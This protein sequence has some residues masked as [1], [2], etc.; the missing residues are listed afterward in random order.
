MRTVTL[1]L[2]FILTLLF[3]TSFAQNILIYPE[4]HR[5]SACIEQRQ[6]LVDKSMS[7]NNDFSI[8]E[9]GY[10]DDNYGMYLLSRDRNKIKDI[11]SF[12]YFDGLERNPSLENQI[13]QDILAGFQNSKL[14]GLESSIVEMLSTSLS[15]ASD[16][17]VLL[18][19]VN[20][21][22][23]SEVGSDPNLNDF[24]K[25]YFSGFL[26]LYKNLQTLKLSPNF[27]TLYQDYD[28]DQL[29]TNVSQINQSLLDTGKMGSFE[30]S[31]QR[32]IQLKPFFERVFFVL[33]EYINFGE[34]DSHLILSNKIKTLLG[35][36]NQS[37]IEAWSNAMKANTAIQVT[38]A[39]TQNDNF[40]NN[41]ENS[42]KVDLR[43]FAFAQNIASVW[44][45][46][47]NDQN[48]H[49]IIG[50]EHLEGLV[51]MLKSQKFAQYTVKQAKC[52]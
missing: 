36:E 45:C 11:F 34:I 51:N 49:V 50:A 3:K 20:T 26:S 44:E 19:D 17:Q 2:F 31:Y 35:H 46:L 18:I 33:Y 40:W 37:K 12:T 15:G 4:A 48:L 30:V 29:E 52:Y 42:I 24:L 39:K 28:L 38:V 8:L 22:G 9:G 23:F 1:T 5:N 32:V 21:F 10:F 47:D 14:F 7:S 43:N 6:T 41:F 16:S 13:A 27:N 25:N